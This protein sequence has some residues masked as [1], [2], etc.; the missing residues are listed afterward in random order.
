MLTPELDPDEPER[1]QALFNATLTLLAA[2]GFD[3]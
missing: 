3:K 1:Q 2:G